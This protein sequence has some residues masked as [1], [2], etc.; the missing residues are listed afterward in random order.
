MADINN[1]FSIIINGIE[2][3]PE[4]VCPPLDTSASI[5][6]GDDLI[7]IYQDRIDALINQL[8]K[9]ITLNFDPVRSVCP[10]CEFDQ[11][12]QRSTGIYIPGGPR[13]FSRGRQCPWCKGRGFEET[14]PT[15]CIKCLL[16]W[17]PKELENYGISTSDTKDIIRLK[18]FKTNYKDLV[19]ARTAIVHKDI[20]AIVKFRVRRLGKPHLVGLRNS[21]YCISFWELIDD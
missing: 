8:G 9:N 12:R 18:T 4:V 2:P 6:I 21:R 15:K 1:E 20:Q 10:N 13:P 11:N 19:K 17:N 16:K 5:Q 7:Q 14:I 3:K